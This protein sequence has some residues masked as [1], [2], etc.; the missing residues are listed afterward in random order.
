MNSETK[1]YSAISSLLYYA[2]YLGSQAYSFVNL[3]PKN[4]RLSNY[5]QEQT[6]SFI[7]SLNYIK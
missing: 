2:K 6:Q 4:K 3:F 5:I 1:F 7:E